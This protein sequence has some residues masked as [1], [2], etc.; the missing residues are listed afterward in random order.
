MLLQMLWSGGFMRIKIAR[1]RIVIKILMFFLYV[2]ILLDNVVGFQMKSTGGESSISKIFRMFFWIFLLYI[3][4]QK[5][6]KHRF[7]LYYGILIVFSMILPVLQ[8]LINESWRGFVTDELY[9]IKLL[10]PMTLIVAGYFLYEEKLLIFSDIEAYFRVIKWIYPIT[11]IVPYMLGLGY[12]SY[13]DSG[14]SGFYAAGNEISI[15]L[16]ITFI[17]HMNDFV[18]KWRFMDAIGVTISVFSVILTG[19]KAGIFIIA[20]A[21]M[22][23][24]FISKMSIVKKLLLIFGGGILV[25]VLMYAVQYFLESELLLTFSRLEFKYHQLGGKWFDFIFSYRNAKIVP[26][27]KIML[28]NPITIL[29]GKGYYAQVVLNTRGRV[30]SA[31]LIE[32]DFFD[33]FLQYGAILA[34][35]IWGGLLKVIIRTKRI[36]SKQYRFAY[37]CMLLYSFMAGHTI[38]SGPTGTLLALLCLGLLLQEKKKEEYTYENFIDYKSLPIKG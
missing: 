24:L 2:G 29:F 20:I 32:M 37:G 26:N 18:K 22:Y 35:L 10:F 16:G 17:F 6:R 33:I 7:K 25:Y 11:I 34:V 15:I 1:R 12:R 27:I 21:I 23:F 4:F 5:G 28:E 14:Y 8:G 38:Y 31:G 13:A 9:V 19:T 30:A 3:I 36:A